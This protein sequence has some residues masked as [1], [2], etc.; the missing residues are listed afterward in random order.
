[1][2]NTRA[3]TPYLPNEIRIR[4][5][6]VRKTAAAAAAAA[7]AEEAGGETTLRAPKE[8]QL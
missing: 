8:F 2:N 4:A 6:L 3:G 5:H 1:M 7:A